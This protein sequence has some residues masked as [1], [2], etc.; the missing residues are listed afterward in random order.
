MRTMRTPNQGSRLGA[1][2]RYIVLHHMASTSFESVLESWRTGRK[3]GSANYA[4]SNQGD[5]VLVV[6]EHMRSWSLSSSTWDSQSV[7]FEIENS[8]RGGLWPV[9]GKAQEATAQVIAGLCRRYG[10]PCDR[11]H[12]LGHREVYTRSN[13]QYSYATACPG[14]LDMDWVVNRANQ[15][16]ATT[17]ADNITPIEGDAMPKFEKKDYEESAIPWAYGTFSMLP[18]TTR[19]ATYDIAR[20][21]ETGAVEV[22]VKLSGLPVGAS[23]QLRICVYE[24]GKRKESLGAVEIIGTTG[25][26]FG[27][28][29]RQ[30]QLSDGEA[31][32]AELAVFADGVKVDR[33]SRTKMYWR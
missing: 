20:G 8:A 22:D 11:E 26:T 30:Y 9:S 25:G 28:H 15:L 33:I 12:I 31:I 5:V 14:G 2:I 10:I 3:E 27:Q 7:T 6:P 24:D 29:S 18:V 16:M 4:I 21:P 1:T 32:R 23:A 17:A 19:A 13:G